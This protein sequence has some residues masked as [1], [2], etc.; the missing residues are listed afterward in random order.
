MASSKLE[1][2]SVPWENFSNWKF[3]VCALLEEKGVKKSIYEG[4]E[5]N[6]SDEKQKLDAT[7]VIII[8]CIWDKHLEYVEKSETAREMIKSLEIESERKTMFS[9]INF[10]KKLLA[11]NYDTKEDLEEH[12]V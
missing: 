8:Q 2:A 4:L 1:S 6:A 5:Y 7:E 3:K 9:K 10:K 12:F 11:L